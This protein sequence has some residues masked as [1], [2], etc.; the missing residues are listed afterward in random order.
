[1]E[2]LLSH[3][4][5]PQ[6]RRQNGHTSLISITAQTRMDLH[7]ITLRMTIYLHHLLILNTH[8]I[9]A[10]DIMVP[11]AHRLLTLTGRPITAKVIMVAPQAHLQISSKNASDSP[12]TSPMD[13]A[14]GE[15]HPILM[16]HPTAEYHQA[17][18]KPYTSSS[19]SLLASS[20]HS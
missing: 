6:G 16:D 2:S 10:K 18:S 12:E 9:V 8:L 15:A 1:M 19:S 11:Q 13:P 3:L 5:I 14:T 7:L 20:S 17:S 4:D